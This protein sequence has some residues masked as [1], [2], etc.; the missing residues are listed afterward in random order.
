MR[1]LVISDTHF[2]AWS[3][4]D[5]LRKPEALERLAPHLDDI[6]ELIFLG[7]LFDLLLG[8]IE[9]AIEH[10]Q[11]FL[12]LVRE[13]LAG[14]R[15]VFLA[16]NHDHHFVVRRAEAARFLGQTNAN[17]DQPRG[18]PLIESF[19]QDALEGVEVEVHYPTYTFANVLCTHGHYLDV[20]AHRNGSLPNRLLQETLWWIAAGGPDDP[21]TI[22]DYEAV[23]TLLTELLYI[24]AQLPNGTT[25]QRRVYGIA[26][27]TGAA[28]SSITRPGRAIER[29]V[30]NVR[31]KRSDQPAAPQLQS[32]YTRARAQEE[33][34]RREANAPVQTTSFPL[35]RVVRPSG[36]NELV[37]ESFSQVVKNLGWGEGVTQVVFAHTHQ[38]FADLRASH[39][40]EIRYW[41]TG[42]WIYEPDLS[43]HEAYVSYLRNGWPGTAVLIDSEE[44]HPR[45]LELLGDWNPLA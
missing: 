24:T 29:L 41:N 26:E 22:E 15:F 19:L 36:P 8:H 14:K 45:L 13:R 4:D 20:H 16:G 21:S 35:A 17:A 25:A 37:L 1:A 38:P 40:S 7:D 23:I 10:A 30:H 18:R 32:E 5:L 2:G 11:G 44:P 3:G 43:S 33:S 9:Q 6:D 28:M 39:G 12:S 42:S 31:G 27:R 34:R